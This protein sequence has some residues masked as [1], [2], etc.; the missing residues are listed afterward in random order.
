MVRRLL[1]LRSLLEDMSGLDEKMAS[2][3]DLLLRALRSG[4]DLAGAAEGEEEEE[5]EEEDSD[6]APATKAPTG[7]K[8]RGASSASGGSGK[9][10]ESGEEEE[11]Q[12]EEEEEGEDVDEYDLEEEEARFMGGAEGPD[13]EDDGDEGEASKATTKKKRRRAARQEAL[14]EARAKLAAGDGTGDASLGDFGDDDV[15]MN[16]GGGGGANILQGMVNRI[17]QRDQAT[18]ARKGRGLQGDLDVPI[19]ERDQTIRVRRPAPGE[20]SGSEDEG[21]S[22][23][24]A[25]SEEDDDDDFL[26]G[27]GGGGF[28]DG[29]PPGLLEGLSRRGGGGGGGD[30]AA[31]GAKKRKSAGTEGKRDRG[32]GGDAEGEEDDEFY[33]IVAEEKERKKRAKKDKY[34]PQARIAGAL[35]AELEAERAARGETKRGASYT[36]IKNRGL[37]PHKNKLNRNPRS[38]KREAFRK[39]TIR[40]KGQVRMPWEAGGCGIVAGRQSQLTIDLTGVIGCTW[41]LRLLHPLTACCVICMRG[42]RG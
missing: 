38:K 5:E 16:G 11:G 8:K 37:T 42:Q 40:R 25:G 27:G 1:S 23:A 4:V 33:A 9:D 20:E 28:M 15:D 32:G 24:A 12:K 7:A 35:E 26:G 29:L 2:Q 19:R 41:H 30:G 3:V 17:S 31:A 10:D 22:G 34:N 18:T 13:E 36:I 14:S 6:G 21:G 39:A